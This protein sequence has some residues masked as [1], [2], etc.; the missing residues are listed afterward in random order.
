MILVDQAALQGAEA[1]VETLR[2]RHSPAAMVLLAPGNRAPAP[3]PWDSI[4]RRP[5]SIEG[6]V[7]AVRS[8]L[9]LAPGA[10]APIDDAGIP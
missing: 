3:G 6:I 1:E 5:V 10:T 9:P 8:L 2:A 4:L 7:A